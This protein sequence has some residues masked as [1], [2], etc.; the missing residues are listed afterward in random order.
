MTSTFFTILQ[1]Y[2]SLILTPSI[3]VVYPRPMGNDSISYIAKV[4]SNFIFGSVMPSDARLLVNEIEFDVEENGTFLA[5]VP[6]DWEKKRYELIAIHNNDSAVLTL[7]FNAYNTSQKQERSKLSF[8][9]LIELTG[10][11]ARTDPQ[12][13]YYIFPE[14]GTIVVTEEYKQ[15]YFKIRL[16][17][18]RAV[19]IMAK[20]VKDVG[21]IEN[22]PTPVMMYGTVKPSGKWVDIVMPVGRKVLYRTWEIT[23]PDKI[24]IE[25]YNVISHI[26][27]IAYTP[28]TDLVREV[29]WDQPE[30]SVV[31]LEILLSQPSW[32]YKVEWE[33]DDLIL[34]VRRPPK[35]KCGVKGLNIVIDP[36]HGDKDLGAVGSTGL[37]EKE[38][39]LKVALELGSYLMRKGAKV[40]LTRYNDSFIELKDRT[41]FAEKVEADILISLHHN[42]LPDGVNPFGNYG[43]GTYYYRPQSRLLAECMQKELVKKL[44]FPD[45]GVY[46]NNL[47]LVRTTAMPSVLIEAAYMMLPK[48][49]AEMLDD[50][51]PKKL[52][53]AIYKGLRGF[54][55]QSKKA[56]K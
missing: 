42:A 41:L 1:I 48:Q 5:F 38:I 29:I 37:T 32:G 13:A 49:E 6:L 36:G 30:D 25:L 4:D 54:V 51:Y 45:E 39:N 56:R 20:Y 40:I 33:A 47:A 10:G 34:K 44:R 11:V 9:R 16:S 53:K 28:G 43:T 12:G 2:T 26:D 22:L 55:K 35:L 3:N 31:R 14:S 21:Q 50:K 8:P 24:F 23:N 46:Y 15:G 27:R 7:P 17:N 18:G 19:W 52:T